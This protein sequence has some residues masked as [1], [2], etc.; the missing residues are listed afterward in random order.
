MSISYLFVA[1]TIVLTVYG[2]LVLK[3]QMGLHGAAV[4]WTD[5]WSIARLLCRPWIVSA[6]GAAFLASLC[7]M[8]AINRLP[9]SRAY[10]YMAI[11]F[12]LV[13]VLATLLF[14]EKMDIYRWAGTAIIMLGVVVLSFSKSIG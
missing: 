4:N 8:A 2:Q 3:W 6:F 13:A 1:L 5:L 14:G 10:P 11:N 7:W 9:I 12:L